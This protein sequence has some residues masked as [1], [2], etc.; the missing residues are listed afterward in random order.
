[1]KKE[2][3]IIIF[4]AL[5]SFSGYFSWKFTDNILSAIICFLLSML[6]IYLILDD[7]ISSSKKNKPE[8]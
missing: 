8:D 6:L 5:V 7:I 1:M 4:M 3:A 2:L